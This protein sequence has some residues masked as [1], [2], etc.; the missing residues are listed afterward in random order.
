M[1]PLNKLVT[2][3]SRRWW[4]VLTVL[5]VN[6]LSF[7]ILFY[8]E[9]R[10]SKVS[11]IPTF[12]TQNSL[13]PELLRNQL[14]AYTGEAKTLYLQFST[15]DFI[16]PFIAALFLAVLWTVLLRFRSTEFTKRLLRY[17]LPLLAFLGTLFDY[18]ENIFLLLIVNGDA[19]PAN[20]LVSLALWSKAG[21]LFVL[22]ISGI[23]TLLL[24]VLTMVNFFR[25]Q[26]TKRS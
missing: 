13:T 7:N 8:L 25:V 4:G 14:P 20:T 22:N 3:F 18:L 15:F 26:N 12:D 6:F 23:V 11:G 21:K 2:F 5:I 17:N 24:I 9:D 1:S 10:F 16:F 19:N